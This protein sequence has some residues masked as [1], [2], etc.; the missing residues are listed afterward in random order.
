M[1]TVR[2]PENKAVTDAGART[3]TQAFDFL[4]ALSLLGLH[5][6]RLAE[7]WRE[8]LAG[9]LEKVHAGIGALNDRATHNRSCVAHRQ[10][11][12]MINIIPLSVY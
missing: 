8:S 4:P 12:F 10:G 5:V 7:N 1:S 3:D 2:R 6:A 9:N 11:R